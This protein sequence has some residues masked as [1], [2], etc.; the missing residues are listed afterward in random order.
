MTRPRTCARWAVGL[1]MH[2]LG[3]WQ[4]TI[5]AIGKV[6]EGWEVVGGV[7]KSS[8]EG[9]LVLRALRPRGEEQRSGSTEAIPWRLSLRAK[10]VEG[11]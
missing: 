8:E 2:S 4:W 10:E 1:E 5:R 3:Y 11:G 9:V 7:A 6:L